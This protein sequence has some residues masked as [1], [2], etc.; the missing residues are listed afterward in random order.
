MSALLEQLFD[1]IFVAGAAQEG[2]AVGL[3]L[4]LR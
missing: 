3:D 2:V 1:D 4:K